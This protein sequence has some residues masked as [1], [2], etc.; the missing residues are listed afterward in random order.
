MYFFG[1]DGAVNSLKIT[2]HLAMVALADAL[3][4][5]LSAVALNTENAYA[6]KQ[7]A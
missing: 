7:Q 4:A 3:I 5:F 1:L 2:V 6:E